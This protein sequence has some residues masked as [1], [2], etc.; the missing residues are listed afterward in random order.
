MSRNC[1]GHKIGTCTHSVCEIWSRSSESV[2]LTVGWLPS[3][4]HAPSRVVKGA[5]GFSFL[6]IDTQVRDLSEG[7]TFCEPDGLFRMQSESS[8]LFRQITRQLMG[9][10]KRTDE[11]HQ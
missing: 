5:I 10:V 6:L 3:I 9:I 4:F 11:T 8:L 7:F 1:G 2:C